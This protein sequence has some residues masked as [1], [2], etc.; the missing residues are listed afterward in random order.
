MDTRDT[1]QQSWEAHQSG[2]T[3]AQVARELRYANGSVARR[4]ALRHEARIGPPP[5]ESATVV[6]PP[7]FHVDAWRGG[8]I[9]VRL[10]EPQPEVDLALDETIYH[11]RLPRA[12]YHFVKWNADGSAQLWGGESGYAAYRDFH[13]RDLSNFP[14]DDGAEAVYAWALQKGRVGTQ[15]SIADLA[16]LLAVP[17][18]QIRKA[19]ALRPDLLRRLGRSTFEVRDPAADRKADKQVAS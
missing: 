8:E 16:T 13:V 4:A 6:T 5:T 15:I 18:P 11:R 14:T 1:D 12:R 9:A 2:K 3:W 10:V 19:V 17:E 7:V